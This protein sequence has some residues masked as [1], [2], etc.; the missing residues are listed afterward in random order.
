MFFVGGLMQI[1][2]AIFQVV[3]NNVYGATA[4]FGFGCF[5]FSNGLIVILNAHF[6]GGGTPAKDLIGEADDWGN[7]VR[8]MFILAFCIGLEIQTFVMNKLS[9]TLI[10]LL[11][12]KVFFHAV[13]PWSMACL[14]GWLT[15]F[16]A[17]YVF[18]TEFTNQVR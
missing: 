10:G 7:F 4:F 2:V 9:S 17:F 3:R 14:F 15:S 12:L 6:S 8:L 16:F 5:W 13:S 18:L 11:C 1:L